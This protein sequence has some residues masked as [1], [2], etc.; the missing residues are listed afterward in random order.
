MKKSL[1]LGIAIFLAATVS[2]AE[3]TVDIDQALDRYVT[4]LKSFNTGVRHNAVFQIVQLKSDHPDMNADK[5]VRALE[6][7]RR[8]DRNP[9]VRMHAE[10]AIIYLKESRFE[11]VK[12]VDRENPMDFFSR[13]HDAIGPNMAVN[14]E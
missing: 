1:I 12:V 9:L 8:K 11:N 13:L 6:G 14:L 2:A 7:L 5:A 3:Y 10:L 4:A